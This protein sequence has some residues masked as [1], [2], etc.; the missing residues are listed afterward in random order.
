MV[1]LNIN[2]S[3]LWNPSTVA[4]YSVPELFWPIL[5]PETVSKSPHS[6]EQQNEPLSSTKTTHRSQ[7]SNKD[8]LLTRQKNSQ[9]YSRHFPKFWSEKMW[10]PSLPDL[11]S[12]DFCV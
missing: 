9:W 12:M 7:K 6:S 1:S 3:L 11:N 4:R 10:P 8:H 5:E 2:I